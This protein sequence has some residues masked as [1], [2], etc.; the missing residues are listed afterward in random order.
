VI[1][2]RL[3]ALLHATGQIGAFFV[4]LVLG[5]AC[6]I[7]TIALWVRVH[8]KTNKAWLAHVASAIFVL[9]LVALF[10]EPLR[11]MLHLICQGSSDPD[12]CN[13]PDL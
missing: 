6:V 12:A 7:A 1:E 10:W 8:E 9:V 13:I 2:T 5:W 3:R 4:W 11:T